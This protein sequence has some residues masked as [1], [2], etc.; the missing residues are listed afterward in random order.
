M[1]DL[2]A[3]LYESL[4]TEGLAEVIRSTDGDL[5]E[6]RGLKPYEAPDRIALYLANLIRSS[7]LGVSEGDRVSKGIELVRLLSDRLAEVLS[8]DDVDRVVEPG[9]VLHAILRRRPDGSARPMPEPLIPLLDTTL[10][11]NAPGEP[12]LW[13]QLPEEAKSADSIDV[14]M[15]FIR[16]SGIVPLV[17]TLRRH[18][19]EGRPLRI[20]TTT[21]T[22]STEQSAL[23]LL[24]EIGA[25]VR[26]SYDLTS[27]RLHAK[28]WLFHRLTGFSTAFIGS[29]NLTYSAQV[30]G[31]E[32]NIRASSARNPDVLSKFAAVFES[33]WQSNDFVPYD[34]DE[35]RTETARAHRTDHGP[36]VILPGIEL[37]AG[38]ISGTPA[39][40]GCPVT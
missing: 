23:D 28:A 14:V 32:W 11:T 37:T 15:A 25:Q 26:I 36:V 29:S 27:T 9:T 20:L 17:E 3:G 1:D 22:G 5:V 30:T 33:Y 6:S 10:L 21:Y 34:S 40:V 35:F 38:A 24:S 31:L 18:C 13:S 2:Q 7:L 16:K 4:L 39:R 8:V 19:A 12:N